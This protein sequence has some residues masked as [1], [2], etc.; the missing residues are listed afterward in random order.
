MKIYT[1]IPNTNPITSGFKPILPNWF[2]EAAV[3]CELATGLVLL[4]LSLL[5]AAWRADVF[6]VLGGGTLMSVE[7]MAVLVAVFCLSGIA[8]AILSLFFMAECRGS[9]PK[10]TS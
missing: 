7:G 2:L 5:P 8:C 9:N 6:F 1:S 4:P 10:K 3:R